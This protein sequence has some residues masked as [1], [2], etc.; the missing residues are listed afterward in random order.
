[1][2]EKITGIRRRPDLLTLPPKTALL[3]LDMQEY[4]LT[5]DSHAFIPNAPPILPLI[6]KL[7]DFF[8]NRG[9]LVFFTQHINTKEDAGMMDEWWQDLI[10]ES[11]PLSKITDQLTL[12]GNDVI[13]KSQYDAFH[14]TNLKERLIE[15]NITGVVITGVMT[16][17]CC[18]TTARS[19]FVN[20]FKV[21]F[22]VDGTA[23]YNE[24][25][26]LAALT[27]LSHGFAIPILV[28]EVILGL[29]ANDEG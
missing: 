7:I 19:A 8:S 10:L 9:M 29:K 23:T 27:N 21:W 4:F 1:M 28:N 5:P 2:L 6:Q 11:D 17:L 26:H 22:T 3:V 20:C 15:Q 25:F 16:H 13:Q 12:A 14:E 24:D 18:E